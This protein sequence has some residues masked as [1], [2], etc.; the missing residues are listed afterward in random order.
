MKFNYLEE[1][2]NTD[3]TLKNRSIKPLFTLDYRLTDWLKLQTQFSMQL[4]H[5]ATEKV[6][7]KETYYVRKYREKQEGTMAVIFCPTEELYRILPKI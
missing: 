7:A 5:S 1:V 6:A 2:D 4:D 3:Y